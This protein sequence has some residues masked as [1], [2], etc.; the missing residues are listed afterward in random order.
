MPYWGLR[1]Y[2]G[3]QREVWSGDPE[4]A[5]EWT[6]DPTAEGYTGT[7]RWQHSANGRGEEQPT[8]KRLR[9]PITRASRPEAWAQIERGGFCACGAWYGAL[10]LEPQPELYVE[11]M[12]AI[13]RE[14]RRVLRQDGTLWCNLGDSYASGRS[15][16]NGING[17]MANREVA[18]H[19]GM[20]GVTKMADGL[21]PKDLVGIPWAVA[22][23][24]QAPYYT[25]RIRDERDRIWLAAMIDGEGCIFIHKRK[26]GQNNGQGYERKNATYGAGLEVANTSE[27]IIN[28][29]AAIAGLGSVFLHK[30]D[31]RQPLYR[32]NL[33]SNQCRDL[34]REVYP[35]LVGKQHQARLLLGCISSGPQAE[36]AH[37]ALIDLHNGRDVTVD[38]PA[39]DS[40]YEPGWYLRS[41]IIWSKLNPM[42]ESV[43]DRPTKSHEYLFLLSK[44]QRYYYDADAIREPSLTNDP[45]HPYTSE[46]AWQLDGRPKAQRKGGQLRDGDDF[47]S[48][49]KRTVW[50]IATRPYSGAHFAT[51]PEQ[52]VEPCIL[53]GS[54][55]G[56]IVVDLF[57]GSGTTGR[58]AIR[59]GRSYVGVDISREYLVEQSR[60]RIDNIQHAMPLDAEL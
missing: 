30:K 47:T 58:V 11:H 8:D 24:L 9:D 42:P 44:S 13:F 18:K 21:K 43:T 60:K 15:G 29:V 26:A 35:Y 56:D 38:F 6:A 23:A 22:K 20:P 40:M 14:V 17:V 55:A 36:A 28:R 4:C 37:T 32:W 57:N 1:Q 54:R 46:G 34:I 19:R 48:R 39:P 33:R 3:E 41:D 50:T 53:A 5:H 7:A 49:N 27:A 25:G 10:G 16:P 12:V 2:A 45:R 31:R 52:L 51:F 59:H